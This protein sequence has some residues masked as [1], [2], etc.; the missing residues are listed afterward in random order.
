M[1]KHRCGIRSQ[2]RGFEYD[3][4]RVDVGKRAFPPN[5]E[6]KLHANNFPFCSFTDKGSTKHFFCLEILIRMNIKKEGF[7]YH[8]PNK[9]GLEKISLVDI[10]AKD[11]RRNK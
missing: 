10:F 9:I 5:K 11:L 8:L 4:T 3:G 1:C 7:L 6:I 2:G